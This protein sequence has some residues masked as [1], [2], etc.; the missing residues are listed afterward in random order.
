MILTV[1]GKFFGYF[2]LGFPPYNSQV[3]DST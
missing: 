2:S 3:Q 1:T